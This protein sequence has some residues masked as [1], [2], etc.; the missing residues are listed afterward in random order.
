M[1]CGNAA[2]ELAGVLVDERLDGLVDVLIEAFA[3]DVQVEI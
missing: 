2:V 3:R 1:L